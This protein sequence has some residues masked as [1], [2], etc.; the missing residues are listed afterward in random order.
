MSIRHLKTRKQFQSMLAHLPI[1]K[2]SHFALHR[3]PVHSLLDAE[4]GSLLFANPPGNAHSSDTPWWVGALVPK[5]WAKHAVTR[6]LVR[7]QVYAIALE[8]SQRASAC[9]PSCLDTPNGGAQPA[10][11]QPHAYLVRLR[12]SFHTANVGKS[13]ARTKNSA[14]K[15]HKS[16]KPLSHSA[17]N[18]A[19]PLFKSAASKR[20]KSA[21]REQL[22]TL[23]ARAEQADSEARLRASAQAAVEVV[24]TA[25]LKPLKEA[26]QDA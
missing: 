11:Q 12:S 26:G 18:V 20:L 1:A 7:R 16:S 3:A 23:F 14:Q 6:N 17:T 4:G 22:L 8:L 5:R 13:A 21:V 24:P 10:V 2:T 25:D 15:S 19:K 9:A